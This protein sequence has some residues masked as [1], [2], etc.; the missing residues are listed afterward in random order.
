MKEDTP[1][2]PKLPKAA[3][4]CARHLLPEHELKKIFAP[5]TLWVVNR[6]MPM[7]ADYRKGDVVEV[8]DHSECGSLETKKRRIWVGWIVNPPRHRRPNNRD[9]DYYV[10]MSDLD[11]LEE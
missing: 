2:K 1:T 5:G 9:F 10:L 11:Y 4:E 7:S 8:V 6:N 3:F